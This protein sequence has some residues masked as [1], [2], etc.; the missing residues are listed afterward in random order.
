MLTSANDSSAKIFKIMHYTYI[1][2][3]KK[4]GQLYTGCTDN[5][6]QR[7]KLHNSGKINATKNRQPLILIH[8]EAFV[9][10]QDAFTRERWLKTGWGR[11]QLK[12]ILQNYFK[13]L[14]G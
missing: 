2:Q 3:S 11:N 9:D 14:G 8:Y 4:D 10:K 1:L 7:F 12:K 13:N 5:L 6:Q